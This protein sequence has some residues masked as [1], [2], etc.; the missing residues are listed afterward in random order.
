M[1]GETNHD[2]DLLRYADRAKRIK[3]KLSRNVASSMLGSEGVAH[4]TKAIEGLKQRI[5]ELE[6]E[7]GSL[8]VRNCDQ[9]K[10]IQ[11]TVKFILCRA[12]SLSWKRSLPPPR[13]RTPWPRRTPS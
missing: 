6:A 3:I 13:R 5:V 1:T 4:Y 2:A 12:K 8:K 7:N 9:I 10:S 11:I